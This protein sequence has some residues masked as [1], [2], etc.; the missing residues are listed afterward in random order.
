MVTDPKTYFFRIF[1]DLHLPRIRIRHFSVAGSESGG[2]NTILSCDFD[3][4]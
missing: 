4:K 1:S 2:S 3:S